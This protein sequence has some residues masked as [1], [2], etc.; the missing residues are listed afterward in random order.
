MI[1]FGD[2]QSHDSLRKP[3][4]VAGAGPKG[5][6]GDNANQGWMCA[7]P[8]THIRIILAFAVCVL[9]PSLA[10]AADAT[11]TVIVVVG[12]GGSDEYT[13]SFDNWANRW[14]AAA[15]QPGTTVVR[16]G[17]DQNAIGNPDAKSE[18]TD[19]ERL[20]ATLDTSIA[21][22][23]SELWLVLIGHGTFD[24]R[25]AK[26]NL[27]GPDVAAKELAEWLKPA[28]MPMAVIN[29]ASSSAP[30]I[31]ALSAPDRTIISATRN[32]A[33]QNYCRFGGYISEL[34]ASPTADLDKDGQTSLLEAWLM[35]SRQTLEFYTSE[36]RLATEHA[37]LDDDGDG[38]G[39]REEAFRGGR[40]IRDKKNSNADGYRA[41]QFH[42]VRSDRERDM[43]PALRQKRNKVEL[44][45]IKLRDRREE[46][47]NEDAYFALLETLL[48]QLASI[49]EE[50]D[51]AK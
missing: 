45:V 43:P 14:E 25:S 17:P 21:N 40:P 30:F 13:A 26:F 36:G 2:S 5:S 9:V 3:T 38:R 18:T 10:D 33:E 15:T 12:T 49:Y 19:R 27:R 42:L 20:K 34:I 46:F 41:H 51:Q 16:I 28:T 29:C 44:A 1:D 24:D 47:E 11:R 50:T 35:A 48:V 37:L 31:N 32:G 23:G 8:R 39:S 4:W 22:K 7:Q 6:P